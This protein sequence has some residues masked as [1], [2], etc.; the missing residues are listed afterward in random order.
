MHIYRLVRNKLDAKIYIWEDLHLS[1][2]NYPGIGRG[3][4]PQ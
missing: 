3:S 4:S 1:F 2:R